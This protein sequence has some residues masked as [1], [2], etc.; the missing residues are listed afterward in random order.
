MPLPEIRFSELPRGVWQHLLERVGQRE[1][2]LREL[3]VPQAWV[4]SR[5]SAPDGDWYKDFG[6]FI[7]CGSGEHPKTVLVKGRKPYGQE[8]D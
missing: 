5:P 6:S 8:I 3:E 4:K 7:L 1:I 2:S